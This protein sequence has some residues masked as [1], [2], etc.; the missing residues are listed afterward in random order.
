MKKSSTSLVK[1]WRPA[2]RHDSGAAA[3]EFAV[4]LLVLAY[5]LLNVFDVGLYL[6][7]EMQVQNAVQMGLQQAFNTCSQ[8]YGKPVFSNCNAAGTNANYGTAAVTS[9]SQSTS[10]GSA[11]SVVDTTEYV[12]GTRQSGTLTGP[13]TSSGD[14]LG[15]KV[16]YTYTP[17]FRLATITSL[18]GTPIIRTH[19]M[20]LS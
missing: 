20:R 4:W 9:G 11:V 5:P 1:W 8:A 15:V 2:F 7:K 14:Y 18:L 10:L 6:Y 12:D 17:L 13:P 16:S 3:V 19:W